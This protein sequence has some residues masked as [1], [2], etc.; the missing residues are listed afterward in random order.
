MRETMLRRMAALLVVPGLAGLVAAAAVAGF[1]G[2]VRRG[3]AIV[4]SDP[5]ELRR[6][7]D[8]LGAGL[9]IEPV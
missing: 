7:A 9:H 8:G 5:I 4:T 3:D 2:A 1:E 6:V